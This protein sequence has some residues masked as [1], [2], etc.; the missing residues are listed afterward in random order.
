MQETYSLK[1]GF[2]KGLLSLVSIFGAL[3][4]FSGFADVSIWDLLTTYL[5]P[6]ISSISVGGLIVIVINW[7]KVKAALGKK[8]R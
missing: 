7:L 2:Y 5:K 3:V 1:K 4:T 6:A 8:N